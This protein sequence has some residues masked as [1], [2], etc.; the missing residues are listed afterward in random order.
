MSLLRL[1][2]AQP[3][4]G[5]KTEVLEH[6]RQRL[7]LS[8]EQFTRAVLLAQNEFSVFL[9][10]GDDERASL[11]ETLTGTDEYSRISMLAFERAKQEKGRLEALSSQLAVQQPLAAEHRQAIEAQK[12]TVERALAGDQQR[13][14]EIEQHLQWHRQYQVLQTAEQQ[15]QHRVEQ[16]QAAQAQAEPR[17]VHV[18]LG[19]VL[20]EARPLLTECDRL[21][22]ECQRQRVS[23][24]P[25]NLAWPMLSAG[26]RPPSKPSKRR[27]NAGTKPN[28]TAC[29]F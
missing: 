13:Q 15:A 9:K 1:P 6:I 26:N 25:P 16:A 27:N 10:A 17:R 4:G 14:A 11:L 8:F 21:Q 29:K 28:A 7:G 24:T 2:E 22:A 19:R 18:A 3:I 12:Q 5:V 20:A 23:S